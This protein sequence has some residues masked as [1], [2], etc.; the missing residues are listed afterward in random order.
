MYKVDVKIKMM[1][2]PNMI[3]NMIPNVRDYVR[4]N[5]RDEIIRGFRRLWF[6]ML[7]KFDVRDVRSF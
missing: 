5:V 7:C 4:S 2:I 1:A 3:P 6:L